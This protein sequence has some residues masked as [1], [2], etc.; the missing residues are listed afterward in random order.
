MNF[1]H[2]MRRCYQKT[3]M[4]P[5]PLGAEIFLSAILS[6]LT[7]VITQTLQWEYLVK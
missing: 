3:R 7:L 6:T 4:V 5:L 1:S 2:Y